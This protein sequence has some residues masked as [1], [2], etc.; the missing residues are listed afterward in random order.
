MNAAPE[1]ELV[2]AVLA[3][4]GSSRFGSDKSQ[5]T[6]EGVRT[7]DRVVGAAMGVASFVV[8]VGG[9]GPL[10]EDARIRIPD[11]VPGGG[12]V[13]AVLS[14]F[15]AMPGKDLLILACDLPLLTPGHLHYLAR[16][17]GGDKEARVPRISAYPQPLSAL[18]RAE[19]GEVFERCWGSGVRSMREVL[20]HLKVDWIDAQTF[21][22]EGLEV[23]QLAD[24]DTPEDLARLRE[25]VSPQKE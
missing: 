8:V 14:A 24:F 1:R 5:V 18:Y 3:G 25:L 9:D 4:G 2:A 7:I 19:C 6:L 13:Q 17:L 16:P 23:G 10:S 11:S 21:Q 15:R 20:E 12:P 22:E